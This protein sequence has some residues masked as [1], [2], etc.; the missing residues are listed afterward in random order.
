MG[1][2]SDYDVIEIVILKNDFIKRMKLVFEHMIDFS[3]KN[4]GLK[5][6]G[7]FILRH[8]LIFSDAQSLEHSQISPK[9]QIKQ[10]E[11]LGPKCF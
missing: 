2:C 8:F 3:L 1:F 11:C 7:F 10:F 4:I 5:I 9:T 6:T